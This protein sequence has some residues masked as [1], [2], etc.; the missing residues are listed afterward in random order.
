MLRHKA[1]IGSSHSLSSDRPLKTNRLLNILAVF[2]VT[3]FMLLE[4]PGTLAVL[5]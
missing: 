3:L 1:E 4:A 2:A 5:L